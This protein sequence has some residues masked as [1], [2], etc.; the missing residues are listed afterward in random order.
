MNLVATVLSGAPIQFPSIS[1]SSILPEVVF[2]GAAV[3]SMLLVAVLG[4]RDQTYGYTGLGVAAALFGGIWS[5]H[6]SQNVN[7]RGAYAVVGGSLAVDGFSTFFMILTSVGVLITLLL[8]EAYLYKVSHRGPEFVALTLLSATGAM[9]MESA[10]DLL[11]LFI[12]LEI[13]SISL[14]VMVSYT[15]SRRVSK[16]SAFK[17]FILGGFASAL[18]LYGLALVYGSTGST[19]LGNIAAFLSKNT[20]TSNGVLL[21]GMVLI[22]GGLGFKVALVPFQFW[23]PDVYQGAPTSVTGF[24]SGVVKAAG[25]AALLR[26]FYFAFNTLR[27]DWQPVLEIVAILTLLVGAVLA[28]VQSDAKR[29]LAYSSIN[30]AGFILLGLYVASA[31]SIGDSLYYLFAYTVMSSGTFG[32]I[33]MIAHLEGRTE[34]TLSLAD[35]RGIG[36]KYPKIALTLA[37]LLLAQ[38]GAPFTIGFL[39]KFSVLSSV[40]EAH[41]Y[42]IAVIAMVSVVIAAVLY[43]RVTLSMYTPLTKDAEIDRVSTD[44]VIS[45]GAVAVRVDEDTDLKVDAKVPVAAGLAMGLSVAMTVG[46][47]LYASPLVQ[48]ASKAFLLR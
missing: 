46:F 38:A 1:Y 19:N 20:L 24:M 10:Y 17:Y 33:S 37:I 25:F 28:V 16:E 8:A 42:V 11:V 44:P 27:A 15:T 35:L 39:A 32:A 31:A 23:T 4:Q 7:A 41:H 21:A 40:V 18:F 2:V 5:Y 29:T 3:L 26:V 45:L 48:F 9:L 13:L 14:Y 6:L 22:L 36:R 34:G 47:G 43:L 30:H 12:G